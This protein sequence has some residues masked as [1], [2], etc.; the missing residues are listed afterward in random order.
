MADLSTTP[1]LGAMAIKEL[2]AMPP[3]MNATQ[4]A[5]ALGYSLKRFYKLER[6][7]S[8]LH[9]EERPVINRKAWLRS[10]VER[11]LAGGEVESAERSFKRHPFTSKQGCQSRDAV[12]SNR[13][14]HGA[15]SKPR[16]G[17][18]QFNRVDSSEVRP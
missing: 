14:V 4:M 3:R 6:Q 15:E 12:R 2:D 9:L 16:S 18:S 1:A 8:F 17:A 10:K 5:Q 11:H 13:D 7:G